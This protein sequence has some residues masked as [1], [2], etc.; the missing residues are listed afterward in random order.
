[1]PSPEKLTDDRISEELNKHPRW[2][3]QGDMIVREISASNFAAAVGVVNAIAVVA[4][5]EQHHPDILIYGWNKVKVSI[6]T[7]DA[8]GLTE[9]DFKMA[10]KI[11]DLNF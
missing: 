5:T 1:M 6:T 2:N 7:H 8:G 4:E 9:N 10:S 3:K 11:D